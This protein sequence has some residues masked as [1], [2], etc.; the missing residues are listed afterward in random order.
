MAFDCRDTVLSLPGSYIQAHAFYYYTQFL[1]SIIIN[2]SHSHLRHNSS[3]IIIAKT[4]IIIVIF[5]NVIV[6]NQIVI[7]CWARIFKL[8]WTLLLHHGMLSCKLYSPHLTG[9]PGKL[10]S[11]CFHNFQSLRLV[12][13]T[14]LLAPCIVSFVRSSLRYD[15]ALLKA[16]F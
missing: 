14:L 1:I 16:T 11:C 15:A 6:H 12:A 13:T 2:L 7:S 10:V 3:I 9:G 4:I 8:P 5:I